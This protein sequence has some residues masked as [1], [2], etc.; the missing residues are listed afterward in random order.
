VGGG[1]A[2]EERAEFEVRSAAESPNRV[3]SPSATRNETL[4]N[5]PSTAGPTLTSDAYGPR[6]ATTTAAS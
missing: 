6:A 3:R 1:S 4:T 5:E 2:R